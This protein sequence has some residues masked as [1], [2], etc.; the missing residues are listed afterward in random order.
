MQAQAQEQEP[1]R[2]TNVPEP[3]DYHTKLSN[4]GCPMA[5]IYDPNTDCCCFSGH[6]QCNYDYGGAYWCASIGGYYDPDVCLCDPTTPVIIDLAGGRPPILMLSA[7]D[8]KIEAERAG[9]DARP[10]ATGRIIRLVETIAHLLSAAD[11]Q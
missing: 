6:G 10:A 4:Y 2:P 1:P 3:A 5:S 7:G 11:R 9:V 8:V